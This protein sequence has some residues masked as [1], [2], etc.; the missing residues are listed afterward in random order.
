MGANGNNRRGI[1]SNRTLSTVDKTIE[2]FNAVVKRVIATVLNEQNDQIRARVIEKWIDIAYECRQLKNFSSLT[3]ILNG[4]LSGCIFRLKTAWSYVDLN[5]CA[6]L[7]CLKDVFGS[8]AD[9]KP[10]RAIL[11]RV[12]Y[13]ITI[14]LSSY[15]IIFSNWMIFV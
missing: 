14:F 5:H 6:I 4:L 7:N 13:Y 10:A 3:A 8:C 12:N 1:N 9:R 15:S 2:Q 11:D